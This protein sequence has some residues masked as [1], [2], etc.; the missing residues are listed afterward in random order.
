MIHEGEDFERSIFNRGLE[1][2]HISVR[3]SC[4]FHFGR[5]SYFQEG[6]GISGSDISSIAGQLIESVVVREILKTYFV[7][8]DDAPSHERQIVRNMISSELVR[9]ENI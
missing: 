8:V 1:M 3:E 9:M 6:I 7:S 2:L 5:G 4:E